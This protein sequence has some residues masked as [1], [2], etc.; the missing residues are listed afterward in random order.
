MRAFG[1]AQQDRDRSTRHGDC[2]CPD[3][4]AWEGGRD[5]DRF[6]FFNHWI[7]ATA[8]VDAGRGRHFLG[9]G[10]VLEGS[11]RKATEIRITHGSRQEILADLGGSSSII[12]LDIRDIATR[13][14]ERGRAV[15]V[16]L[17]GPFFCPPEHPRFKEVIAEFLEE[18]DRRVAR[19][20]RDK[21]KFARHKA[22][23]KRP[24]IKELKV[25]GLPKAATSKA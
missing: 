8:E 15:G 22:L 5:R 4:G 12:T 11:F 19:L 23:T 3:A 10:L 17:S 2:L 25:A 21:Q 16:A 13:L 7:A 20:R 9:L 1:Y 18:R 6:R 14:R 24:D